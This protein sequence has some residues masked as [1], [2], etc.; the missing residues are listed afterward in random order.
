MKNLAVT[1]FLF[2]LSALALEA[3]DPLLVRVLD[4]NV[5]SCRERHEVGKVTV[6][7][8]VGALSVEDRELRFELGLNFLSCVEKDERFSLDPRR[9][10]EA[11]ER[12]DIDGNPVRIEYPSADFFVGTGSYRQLGAYAL[13]NEFSQ[14]LQV[15]ANLDNVLTP[16][17][18][19]Q[20]E[21]GLPVRTR[22]VLMARRI[23]TMVRGGV[24][25]PIGQRFL[26]SFT[27]FLTIK[28]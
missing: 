11:Y 19:A 14:R 28:P 1:F 5:V 15:R 3:T 9:P 2:P 4:G 6:N 17:E 10:L 24:R 22:L 27:L 23:E 7:P 21:Q 8:A 25:T 26:G 20:L 18:K 13:A 16:A 12:L